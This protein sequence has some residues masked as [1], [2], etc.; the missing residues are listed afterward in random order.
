MPKLNGIGLGKMI[1]SIYPRRVL[2][3]VTAYQAPC[4]EAIYMN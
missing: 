4:A 1:R 3:C 2:I